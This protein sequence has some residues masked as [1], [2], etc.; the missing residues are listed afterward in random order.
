M[1]IYDEIAFQ[2]G[3]LEGEKSILEVTELSK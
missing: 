2:K 3:I 1:K